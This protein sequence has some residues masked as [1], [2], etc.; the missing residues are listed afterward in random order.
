MGDREGVYIVPRTM[1]C[2]RFK[3]KCLSLDREIERKI[4]RQDLSF[5]FALIGIFSIDKT[6]K[7]RLNALHLIVVYHQ[8]L[9]HVFKHNTI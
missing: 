7:F 4:K 3:R 6:Y 1:I 9:K 8:K 5:K 2:G